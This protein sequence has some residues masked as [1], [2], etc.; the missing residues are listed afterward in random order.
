MGDL[1]TLFRNIFIVFMR[2]SAHLRRSLRGK[3]EK[4]SFFY[5]GIELGTIDDVLAQS[6]VLN[7]F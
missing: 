1:I 6:Y 4:C 5:Q 3:T 7:S 2:N